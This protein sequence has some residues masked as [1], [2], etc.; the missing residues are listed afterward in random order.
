MITSCHNYPGQNNCV[1]RYYPGH[2]QNKL[3]TQNGNKI[4][5]NHFTLNLFKHIFIES[6]LGH[7]LIVIENYK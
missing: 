3:K 4:Y 2:H 5:W 6:Q 7:I 1:S